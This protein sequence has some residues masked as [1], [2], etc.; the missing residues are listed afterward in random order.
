MMKQL[1]TI[2][3]LVLVAVLILREI[4][5]SGGSGNGGKIDTVRVVD[6]LW[7]KHD[8]TIY[9]KLTVKETIHDTMPPEY[10]PSPMYDSLLVQ[11][12]E[13]AKD[14]LA[15]NIYEDTLKVPAIKGLFIVKD[16]VK[17]NKLLGRSWTA[18]FILP[19]V[20]ETVTITKTLP[21]KRQLFIG[22]GITG[23]QTQMQSINAGILYKTRKER[24]LGVT[25]GIN[26]DFKPQVGV[27][28]YWKLF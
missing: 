23:S 24:I 18:D 9:K 27:S 16:T 1:S 15:R 12:N 2:I 17:N 26:Q 3:I 4:G 14:F 19:T 13:L 21:P 22:G 11:Y 6:T 25:G 20:K 5:C 8:T 10:L 28:L 7:E